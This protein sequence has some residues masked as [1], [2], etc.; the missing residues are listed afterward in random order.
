MAQHG[1]R[2]S[3]GRFGGRNL[4]LQSDPMGSGLPP[5]H[6]IPV[7]GLAAQPTRS[8]W[9]TPT[10][11]SRPWTGFSGF[12]VSPLFVAGD[13]PTYTAPDLT[14]VIVQPPAVIL[15]KEAKEDRRPEP[16]RS[17]LL[18]VK[19]TV[20]PPLLASDPPGAFVI[21]ERSGAEH[22]ATAV[23]AQGDSVYYVDTQERHRRIPLRDVDRERTREATAR[24]SS[25]CDCP[26]IS[27]PVYLN[28]G[29]RALRVNIPLVS[30]HRSI[31][32]KCR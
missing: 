27:S 9:P 2:L 6:P 26:L 28:P 3:I 30:V 16:I 11:R 7:L 31:G 20:A 12:P 21:V 32:N 15:E 8:S 17:T 1:G 18:E 25:F 19:D 23:V 4:S 13:G 10:F 5:V 14:V 24:K 29:H 22:L